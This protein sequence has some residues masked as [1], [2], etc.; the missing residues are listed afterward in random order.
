MF[1]NELNC[2]SSE[3]EVYGIY[4]LYSVIYKSEKKVR[5]PES[6]FRHAVDGDGNNNANGILCL[7]HAGEKTYI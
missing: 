3:S 6:H 4:L 2:Q 5:A 7:E 1:I